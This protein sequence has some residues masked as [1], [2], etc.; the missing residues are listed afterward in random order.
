[1]SARIPACSRMK[2]RGLRT[3][4]IAHALLGVAASATRA[5]LGSPK[6]ELL[7]FRLVH[8]SIRAV[9][10]QDVVEATVEF[11]VHNRSSY[12]V[13]GINDCGGSPMYWVE[14]RELDSLGNESWRGVFSAGCIGR[15]LPRVLLPS[16]SARFTS[17]IVAF[18]GQRPEFLFSNHHD[19]FRVVLVVS[20]SHRPGSPDVRAISST[21]VIRAPREP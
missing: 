18:P 7:S 16:D 12:V 2:N 1:V 20:T 8:D 21:F 9:R 13:Y 11:M 19:V 3:I 5:Q 10:H 17:P 4:L 15:E 14:R 6:T